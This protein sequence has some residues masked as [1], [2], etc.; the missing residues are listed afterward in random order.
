MTLPT[1][2]SWRIGRAFGVCVVIGRL[3]DGSFIARRALWVSHGVVGTDYRPIT[4]RR[5]RGDFRL[6]DKGRWVV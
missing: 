6:G 4:G 1:L 5:L 3:Q 2:L